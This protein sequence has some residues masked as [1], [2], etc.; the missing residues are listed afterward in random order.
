MAI[1]AALRGFKPLGVAARIIADEK[2][3]ASARM[4][5]AALLVDSNGAA[6]G[7]VLAASESDWRAA[8]SHCRRVLG[9]VEPIDTWPSAIL[10]QMSIKE[11]ERRVIEI[12]SA[13]RQHRAEESTTR[14]IRRENEIAA[15]SIKNI[16]GGIGEHRRNFS[17]ERHFLMSKLHAPR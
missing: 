16:L 7:A 13:R 2:L 11:G 5:A 6:S 9:R 15:N 8:S 10:L 17:R 4:K 3:L 1:G 14:H 12:S